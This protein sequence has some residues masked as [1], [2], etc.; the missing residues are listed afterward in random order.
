MKRRLTRKVKLAALRSK[1]EEFRDLYE[2]GTGKPGDAR[3]QNLLVGPRSRLAQKAEGLM[4]I[5]ARAPVAASKSV[6]DPVLGV[7]ANMLFGRKSKYGPYGGTRLR[8]VPSSGKGVLADYAPID[9]S[10]A[11][12]IRAGEVPGT[13]KSIFE[14]TPFGKKEHFLKRKS[15]YGGLVGFAQRHPLWA[16]G[17]GALAYLLATDPQLRQLVSGFVPGM[18]QNKIS[19]DVLREFSKQPSLNDPFAS[20]AW[21]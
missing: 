13:T 9:A 16:T 4:D 6:I 5:F 18:P 14:K 2:G 15:T 3:R 21:R 12:K 11:E 17:G 20:G 7:P 8:S 1:T 19:P 10:M